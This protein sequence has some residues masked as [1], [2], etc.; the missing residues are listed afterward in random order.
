[1][2]EIFICVNSKGGYEQKMKND[3]EVYIQASKD[4]AD[5]YQRELVLHA[6]DCKELSEL[7]AKFKSS[8]SERKEHENEVSR[9]LSNITSLEKRYQSEAETKEKE[10]G[11]MKKRH[12]ELTLQNQTLQC[13]L[14]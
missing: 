9:L 8:E 13:P 1:M 11:S 3:I 6:N 14:A 7:K 12:A 4:A 10:L 5:N 2:L